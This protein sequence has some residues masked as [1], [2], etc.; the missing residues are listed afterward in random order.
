MKLGERLLDMLNTHNAGMV[1][2]IYAADFLGMDITDQSR[3]EGA[4][5]ITKRLER[6]WRAFPDLCFEAA[7]PI[8]QGDRASM[9]WVAKGTHQGTVM[10]IPPTGRRVAINGVSLMRIRQDRIAQCIFV[11]DMAG[12][13]RDLGLLPELAYRTPV[14]PPTFRDAVALIAA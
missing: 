2:E 1:P 4:E 13:L 10:N 12:L 7:E 3:L 11:W 8:V 5:G 9:Y 6:L 14:E